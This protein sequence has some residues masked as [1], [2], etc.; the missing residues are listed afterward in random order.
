MSRYFKLA[1]NGLQTCDAHGAD[2][3]RVDQDYVGNAKVAVCCL[4]DDAL[5]VLV[6]SVWSVGRDWD[7][8]KRRLH[9]RRYRKIIS[10]L[11]RTRKLR[12]IERRERKIEPIYRDP[13]ASFRSQRRPKQ[14]GA[15]GPPC[16][17]KP[18]A[19]R[20]RIP[21]FHWSRFGKSAIRPLPLSSGRHPA[22]TCRN[23]R[24]GSSRPLRRRQPVRRSGLPVRE[25]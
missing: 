9:A 16:T 6:V 21:D 11:L 17:P 18:S 5:N 22:G 14:I 7:A 13:Q 2:S 4:V 23:S 10:A 15:A 8:I 3:E 20:L 19:E 24:C 1:W 12:T 25:G